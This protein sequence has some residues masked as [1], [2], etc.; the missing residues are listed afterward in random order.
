[1]LKGACLATIMGGVKIGGVSTLAEIQAAV[2]ALPRL[3]QEALLEQ[4]SAKLRR[5]PVRQV[6][7]PPPAVPQDELRRIHAMIEAEFSRVDSTRQH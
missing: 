2:E 3:E 1:M 4:L 5:A 6:P 7:I